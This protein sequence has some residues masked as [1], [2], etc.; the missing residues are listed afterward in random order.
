MNIFLVLVK[1]EIKEL[2][3]RQLLISI[4]AMLLV[5]YV[6]GKVVGTQHKASEARNSDVVVLDLD[7]SALSKSLIGRLSGA[8]YRVKKTSIPCIDTALA[9]PE[10]KDDG[11]FMLIPAGL[12][13]GLDAGR[14]G[15]IGFYSKFTNFSA[16]ATTV[17]ASK[18]RRTITRVNDELSV[19]VLRKRSPSLDAG[20]ARE[21]LAALEFVMV[22]GKLEQVSLGQALASIQSQIFFFPVAMFF[23]VILAAQM[24][25]TSVASEKENKTLE[26][27]LSSPLDRWMLVVSKLSA[28]ALIA[29]AL[30]GAYMLGM[31][32]FMSGIT[33]QA[34]AGAA[35]PA[36]AAL[37]KLGLIIAPSG[38][39]L[40]GLS[41]LFCIL[42]AL[43][44]AFILGVLSDSVKSIQVTIMPLMMLLMLS[45]ILPLFID[46]NA[47]PLSVRLL[48]YAIP[49]THAF[50]A[51]QNV[52]LHNNAQVLWG[53]LYQAGVFA[54]F[55]TLAGKLFSGELLLTLKSPFKKA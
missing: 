15:G 6:I 53:I 10:F 21:P 51:P 29:G 48:L 25:M 13:K 5:F 43:S 42:C 24:V 14:K 17:T 16:S 37:A 35:L 40:I 47:A 33:A 30:S 41:V 20:F 34:A 52:M 39:L 46:I 7:G 27:L 11:L 44:I 36:Q 50:T 1:K 38:Y 55:V 32:S 49:F 12:Q 2:L 4:A 26:T 23:I 28:S 22:G 54:V 18:I 3:T 19:Y 31:R 8:G 45:Y 9:A